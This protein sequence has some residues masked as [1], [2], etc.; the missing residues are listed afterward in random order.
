MLKWKRLT[1]NF[2]T[3]DVA[4]ESNGEAF[5]WT[6]LYYYKGL[7]VDTGCPH[8]AE[9]AADFLEKMELDVKA[10]LLSHFHEDHCGGAYSFRKRFS[11]N[12]FAPSKSIKIIRNPPEIPQYRQVVWGQP[13]PVEVKP[14]KERMKFGELMVTTIDTPGHSFDHVSFLIDDKLFIG[15]MV[16]NQNPIIIMKQEDYI[17][18][19]DSLRTVLS[20]EFEAAYGGHGIWDRDSI[21]RTLANILKLREKVSTL[22][23]EGLSAEQI[24]EKVLSNVPKKVLQI[25]EQSRFEWSRKNL[26]ES[27]LGHMHDGN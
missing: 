16:T 27:L 3:I 22:A 21:I 23:T 20:L 10:V 12:V 15:D 14:L 25:E 18:L 13:L 19:I 11:V 8:T 17:D 9:E 5:Y 4:R 2:I 24:V 1:D 7:V 6:T 26:V